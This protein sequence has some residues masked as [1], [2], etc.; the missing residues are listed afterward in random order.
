MLKYDLQE[1]GFK[2]VFEYEK[3]DTSNYLRF[4]AL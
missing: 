3:P 1:Q 4:P 2:N